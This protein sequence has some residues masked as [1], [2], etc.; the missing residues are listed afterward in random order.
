MAR[1]IEKG[2]TY[3]DKLCHKLYDE[4]KGRGFQ[5]DGK[6]RRCGGPFMTYYCEDRLHLIACEKCGTLALTKAVSP[7]VAANLTLRQPTLTPPN[8]WVSVEEGLPDAEKEVRLFCITPNGYSYQCQGFYVPPGMRRDDS[9][10]S[11]DWEC[12]DQYDETSDDYFVNPGWYESS[13]N[14]DEYS[15]FGIADK[16]THWMPLPE[17]PDRRP[18]EGE[19]ETK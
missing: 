12:C 1:A 8:E 4:P 3:L 10:Y 13:H 6:C 5:V 11:W 14:W 7:Q 18:P 2:A 17:P 19:E 16:V 9:D 15:A